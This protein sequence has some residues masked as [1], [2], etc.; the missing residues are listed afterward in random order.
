METEMSNF[1]A[2]F[3]RINAQR[4]ARP[5]DPEID[6]PAVIADLMEQGPAAG[7]IWLAQGSQVVEPQYALI[8]Q[9]EEDA[10]IVTV[11]PMNNDER[12]QDGETLV[13]GDNPL[14]VAMMAWP[15]CQTSIPVRVLA[16]PMKAL[17]N[18]A[19]QAVRHDEEDALAVVFRGRGPQAEGFARDNVDEMFAAFIHWHDQCD[20]L[21]KLA[22]SGARQISVTPERSE[23]LRRLVQVLGLSLGQAGAIIDGKS[24]L[25]AEQIGRLQAAGVDTTVDWSRTTTLPD[26]LL[27]E[28]EQPMWRAVAQQCATRYPGKDARMELAREAFALAARTN[29]HGREAWRGALAM[30]AQQ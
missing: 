14:G 6:D 9:V 1:L 11:I 24:Q 7:Q 10:R 19:F 16:R 4:H 5:R 8:V 12:C 2:T 30:A 3:N 23:Y 28:V 13:V 21:P 26:D 22:G 20:D 15:R 27:I 29:G 17:S 25:T 18:A